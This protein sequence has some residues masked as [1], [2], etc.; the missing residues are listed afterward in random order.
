MMKNPIAEPTRLA[1]LP[2]TDDPQGVGR[3]FRS[4][5]MLPEEELP[6]LKWRLR[7]SLYRRSTRASRFFRVA[8]VAGVVFCIGGVVG[9]AVAPLWSKKGSEEPAVSRN[10]PA[11]RSAKRRTTP[12]P[13]AAPAPAT[14]PDQPGPAVQ[15]PGASQNPSP[16][17][18]SGKHASRAH[19]A[20]ANA[21]VVPSASVTAVPLAVPPASP[22]SPQ[23]SS[24]ALEQALLGDAL[25]LLRDGRDPHAA[26]ALLTQ[27]AERFPRGALASEAEMVRIEALLRVGRRDDALSLLDTAPIESLPNRDERLVVRGE[28]RAA[29]GRWQEAKRDFDEMLGG[30]GLPASNAKLRALQERALWGRASARS[31]LGDKEG[32]RSDIEL[33]LH[34]FPD[35]Q[36]AEQAASLLKLKP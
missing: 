22:V 26:L 18:A 16:S 10:P 28:L 15:E 21:P 1:R 2:R 35:G 6:K 19:V 31:R 29:C 20:L 17:S 36:F 9:A 5:L 12:S 25:K 30:R 8:L 7:T 11:H 3:L 24:I 34:Q 13:A 33:C 4:A 27:H 23:P 32:A 14:I